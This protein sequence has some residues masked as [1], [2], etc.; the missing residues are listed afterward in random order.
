MA[1]ILFVDDDR[2]ALELYAPFLRDHGHQVTAVSDGVHAL[3]ALDAAHF[4]VLVT[5]MVMPFI[6]GPRLARLVRHRYAGAPPFIVALSAATL[7]ETR[8]EPHPF[9]DAYVAKGPFEGTAPILLEVINR[10]KGDKVV[11]KKR[12]VRSR[13]IT[14]ELLESRRELEV[15]LNR[16]TQGVVLLNQE[17]LVLYANAPALQLLETPEEEILAQKLATAIPGARDL[18][19]AESLEAV[20]GTGTT[21]RTILELH[22]G[23]VTARLELTPSSAEPEQRFFVLFT[24][25]TA[26][27]TFSKALKKSERGYRAIVES[28]TDLLW[29]IDTNG[30]LTYV[31]PSKAHFT[32]FSA[33][34]YYAKGA[35]ILFGTPDPGELTEIIENALQRCG[36]GESFSMERK[37]PTKN[38]GYLWSLIRVSPL[39]DD[40]GSFIGLRCVATNVHRRR[41]AEEQ[42]RRAVTEREALIRE[43]HHRVKNSVQLIISMLRLRASRFSDSEV[44]AASREMENRF[45]V[46]ATVYS[47]LYEYRSLD[48]LEG[49]T[50]IRNVVEL[51]RGD[52]PSF[53]VEIRGEPFVLALDHAIP[54]GLVIRELVSN[55][56]KHVAP[57]TEAPRLWV[58]WEHEDKTLTIRFRD[59]GPGCPGS[60][61]EQ[62]KELG[63]LIA[64]SL[65]EQLGGEIVMEESP[66]GASLL[67][68][69]RYHPPEPL[70]DTET[71]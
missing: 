33:G 65:M 12:E 30:E 9:I 64:G 43:I 42:L 67:V 44:R 10:R 40:A 49:S 29:T 22:G 35:K 28:T 14:E 11:L 36:K 56:G 6:D 68:T 37:L 24:D 26:E 50:L 15:I 3:A 46:I 71:I 47:H 53:E 52:L 45:R 25:V 5:D 8:T 16:I 21:R 66:E 32:G 51:A 20:A 31:N 60:V 19:S 18:L 70:E 13:R 1:N 69:A 7:E 48:R 27:H 39:R 34:E 41:L 63:L 59:N 23:E 38:G 4:N 55:V 57:V 62:P 58:Q 61:L 54:L 2:D 17:G